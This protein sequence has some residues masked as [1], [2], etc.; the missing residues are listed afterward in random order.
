MPLQEQARLAVPHG[1]APAPR[2]DGAAELADAVGR[3]VTRTTAAVAASWERVA[4]SAAAADPE[5]RELIAVLAELEGGKQLRARLA[6]AAY[7][8]MG[9]G[10]PAVCD[11]LGAAVQLLHTGLCVHDDLIDGD[12]RRHG[13]PNVAGTVLNAWRAAGAAPDVATRQADSAALLAGD[14]AISASLR[15][16]AE[17]PVPPALR[18]ELMREVLT[19]LDA[20]IAGELLD[21]R[22]ERLAPGAARPI[23]MAELKTAGYSVILPLRLGAVASGSADPA[24]LAA[25]AEYGRHLGIAYQLRDDELAVF[26]DAGRTGKSTS[27]DV[28]GGK[29]TRLLQLALDGAEAADRAVL[30]REVGRADATEESVECVRAI[31]RRS[32]AL[33]RHRALVVG[34]A[35]EAVGALDAGDLPHALVAYLQVIARGVPGR[36]R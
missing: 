13:R 32:G 5:L 34:H 8:G 11:A 7:L 27:S 19:A 30:E 20:A 18:L 14:L 15:A 3:A 35:A 36:D 28:R 4:D 1:I 31:M 25:L 10:D 17:V 9:G 33:E 21:V 22:S 29:R 24:A 26:G 23:R 12:D 2:I 6:V 16:V